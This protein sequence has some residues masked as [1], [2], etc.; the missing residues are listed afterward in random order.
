MLEGKGADEEWFATYE[1][2][3]G[4]AL[5]LRYPSQAKSTELFLLHIDGEMVRFKAVFD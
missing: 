1:K 3:E 2:I 4:L 5:T